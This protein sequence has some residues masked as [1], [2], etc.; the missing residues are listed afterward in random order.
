L[1]E[2]PT[3][4][5]RF[6]LLD[7]IIAER[8]R[9]SRSP[10]AKVVW[11]WRRLSATRGRVGIGSLASELGWSRR[12]LAAEFRQHV[13][14][15]PKVVARIFRFRRAVRL[16]ER[17]DDISLADLALECGYFDQAHLNRDFRQFAGCTPVGFGA[18]RLPDGGGLAGN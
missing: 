3:W 9:D 5:E 18:R 6:A 15:T 14:L 4:E 17:V 13:G 10:S 12:H 16:L 8:L 7:A 2:A 1:R 11:A